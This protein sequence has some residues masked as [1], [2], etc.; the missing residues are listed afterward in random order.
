M[1]GLIEMHAHLVLLGQGGY[2][3]WFPWID[4]Q[5][6]DA[7]LTQVME[8]S[9]KQLL[10]AGVTTAVDLGAPLAESLAVRDRI[11]KGEIAGPRMSMSGPWLTRSVA[12]CRC[13]S[14]GRS[15]SPGPSRRRPRPSGWPR[16]A[17]T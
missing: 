13:R 15:R 6:R 12:I 10:M 17:W 7:M 2:E 16:P 8:I 1:P 9:A 3:R 14:F 11:K 5:D 4:E